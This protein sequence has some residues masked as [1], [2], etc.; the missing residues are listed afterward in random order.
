MAAARSK[1]RQQKGKI[2]AAIAKGSKGF[3]ATSTICTTTTITDTVTRTVTET[4]EVIRTAEKQYQEC[5][6]R[7]ITRDP[8]KSLGFGAGACA[9]GVCALTTFVDMVVGF[10]D[11]VTTITEE[12]TRIVVSCTKPQQYLW[13]TPWALTDTPFK[14]GA[15]PNPT[16]FVQSHVDEA[17]AFLRT[18]GELLFG[19][20]ARCL[21]NGD[22]S[23]A[24]LPT[25]IDLGGG[26]LTIPY[27]IKVCLDGACATT[28]SAEGVGAEFNSSFQPLMEALMGLSPET[29][30]ALV[31]LSFTPNVT[32]AALAV[33]LP[34]VAV[35]LAAVI[36]AFIILAL[37]YGVAINVQLSFHRNFTNDFDDN[38]VCIEHPS[39]AIPLIRMATLGFA[40]AELIPPIVTG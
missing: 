16:R 31:A 1:S 9:A 18:N 2:G 19:P 21:I 7:Q 30:A 40:P 17:R 4:I 27:G 38:R 14:D 11:V 23:I 33:P 34:E 39:F 13:S 8:C 35:G 24:A 28:L 5:Y 12:V 6:D 10:V 22:W 36:L 25:P 15:G 26:K 37:I 20:F 29:A 32:L 3:G